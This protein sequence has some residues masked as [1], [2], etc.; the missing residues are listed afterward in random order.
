M[1]KQSAFDF[2]FMHAGHGRYPLRESEFAARVRGATDLALV[3]AIARREGYQFRW[4][5]DQYADDRSGIEHDGPL[6]SCIMYSETGEFCQSLHGIDFG[7]DGDPWHDPYGRVVQAE[8]ASE[9]CL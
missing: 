2:F 9:Q 5:I 8:L 1:S 6:Y 4:E 7:P 3:E